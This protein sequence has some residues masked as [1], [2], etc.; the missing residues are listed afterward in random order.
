MKHL[1]RDDFDGMWGDETPQPKQKSTATTREF[2]V[3]YSAETRAKMSAIHNNR[4]PEQRAEIS[5]KLSAAHKN[6]TPASAETRAKISAANKG[7]II[8]AEKNA[9]RSATLK[10]KT[11]EQRAEINAKIRAAALARY[12]NPA[13]M[14]EIRAKRSAT[15]KARTPEQRAETLAKLRAT[16]HLLGI[17]RRVMTPY[18]V[19]PSITAVAQAANRI[20]QT[21]RSWMKKYPKHYYYLPKD[22]S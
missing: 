21:V 15:L 22:A 16:R 14:A 12:K 17:S 1:I 2:K 5:A 3:T 11:P 20:T 19:Y 7:R 8:S 6:R 18:G 4:T 10:N 13:Q 9:K